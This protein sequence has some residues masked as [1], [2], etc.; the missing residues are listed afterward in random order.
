MSC[1]ISGSGNWSKNPRIED[2]CLIGGNGT[3]EFTKG[4]INNIVNS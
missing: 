4:W 2:Y 3:F 1:V